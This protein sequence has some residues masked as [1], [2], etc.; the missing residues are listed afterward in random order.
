MTTAPG[1]PAGEMQAYAPGF[2]HFEENR[3][4]HEAYGQRMLRHVRDHGVRQVLS[5]GVGH[6]EVARPLV[7][8]LREGALDRYV[9]VDAAPAMIER[10]RAELGELPAGLELVQGWFETLEHEQRFGLI[11]GGFVLEH[12]EDPGRVLR[13]MHSLLAP[14]GRL[15]VAVPNARSLHRLLGHHAGLLDDLYRLGEA[16]HALGHLRYFDLDRLRALALACGW[17]VERAEGLLL[18][19]FTTGQM[20]KLALPPAV[21]QA[22]QQ[23]AEDYPEI[24]NAFS[25]ELAPCS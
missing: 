16:D 18:K 17:R 8:A 24:S 2:A 22:L 4:V 7:Q 23:V 19:P 9:V 21:W 20:Q 6:M 1:T 14:Q 5:L 3:I 25:L 15:F 13:H 10:F 11:E 12:V